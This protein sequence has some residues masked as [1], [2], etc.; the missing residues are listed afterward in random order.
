MSPR[1]QRSINCFKT[2][3]GGKKKNLKKED[4]GVDD[5]FYLIQLIHSDIRFL[6]ESCRC[7]FAHPSISIQ[8]Q[9]P[10]FFLFLWDTLCTLVT[11]NLSSPHP[12]YFS[13]HSWNSAGKGS[14]TSRPVGSAQTGQL[15]LGT[16]QP[17]YGPSWTLITQCLAS[18]L[19]FLI[20]SK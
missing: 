9:A 6:A 4:T 11:Q 16:Q 2:S 5:S 3:S 7:H 19:Q 8:L 14:C 1:D 13:L 17:H 20:P 10:Q 15:S 18:I 12:R